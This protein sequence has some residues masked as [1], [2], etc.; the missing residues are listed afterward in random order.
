MT[1]ETTREVLVKFMNAFAAWVE[2]NATKIA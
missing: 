2:K 1:N